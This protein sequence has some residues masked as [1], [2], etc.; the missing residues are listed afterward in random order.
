MSYEELDSSTNDYIEE[1]P[2]KNYLNQLQWDMAIGLQ[3][4]DNLKPSKYFTKLYQENVAGKMTIEEVKQD[5]KKYYVSKEETKEIN[6]NELECD[7]VSARIVELLNNK[8]IKGIEKVKQLTL[9]ISN[10]EVL[11]EEI[12]EVCKTLKDPAI[13]F[14]MEAVEAVTNLNPESSNIEYLKFASLYVASKSNSLKR[15][16]ARVI[17]NIAKLYPNDLDNSI[18]DLLNNANNE[19]TVVRWSAAY[20]LSRI[21]IIPKYSN[22]DLLDKLFQLDNENYEMGN[23]Q[24][25]QKEDN[26]F[27]INS[28]VG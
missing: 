28:I 4:V 9:A 5:L 2:P 24:V 8:S 22:S 7:F 25:E 1:S 6:H 19:G 3:E 13:A 17:G 27:N 18:K 26:K 16:S 12:I 23:K 14:C 20:A 21:V 15:E 10:K 11:I